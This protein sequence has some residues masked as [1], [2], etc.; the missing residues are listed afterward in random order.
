MKDQPEKLENVAHLDHL[1]MTVLKALKEKE[2]LWDH[3]VQM[4]ETESPGVVEKK[5][6]PDSKDYQESQVPKV[7]LEELLTVNLF[8]V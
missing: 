7:N 5:V 6:A 4:V 8:Q 3:Q 2:D 1:D